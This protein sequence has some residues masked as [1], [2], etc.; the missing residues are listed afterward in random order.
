MLLMPTLALVGYVL[1]LIYDGLDLYWT[2]LIMSCAGVVMLDVV[3]LLYSLASLCAPPL[4]LEFRTLCITA[5]VSFVHCVLS[6]S[7]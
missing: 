2:P 3:A 6:S 7:G 1:P 4:C 5:F